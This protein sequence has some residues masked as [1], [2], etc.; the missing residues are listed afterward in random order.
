MAL[1]M[2]PDGKFRCDQCKT[3]EGN[4]AVEYEVET[5]VAVCITLNDGESLRG[6]V[7]DADWKRIIDGKLQAF[8]L[9]TKTMSDKMI[10]LPAKL[11]RGK[12]KVVRWWGVKYVDEEEHDGKD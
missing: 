10:I 11:G 2:G 5:G 9:W 12:T 8:I 7:S 3:D 4:P 6:V 1:V